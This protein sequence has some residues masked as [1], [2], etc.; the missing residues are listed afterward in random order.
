MVASGN[1]PL[2]LHNFAVTDS[3][4]AITTAIASAASYTG[5]STQLGLALSEAVMDIFSPRNANYRG[6][7]GVAVVLTD[8]FSSETAADMTAAA[9]S[10]QQQGVQILALGASVRGD[11]GVRA[12]AAI[13]ASPADIY[14]LGAD[15]VSAVSVALGKAVACPATVPAP[16]TTVRPAL[17]A[18]GSSAACTCGAGCVTCAVGSPA[19]CVRCVSISTLYNGV[20]VSACPSGYSTTT[21]LDGSSTCVFGTPSLDLAFVVD[22]SGSISP[23]TFASVKQSIISIVNALP[24]SA[25]ETRYACYF[26]CGQATGV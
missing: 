2:V 22:S 26:A 14:Y 7:G 13:T 9:L 16:A 15:N 17:C 18:A 8:G 12:L 20:C 25:T 11:V 10:L 6:S 5:S 24:V 1:L 21:N 3:T 23:A 4:A 19:V